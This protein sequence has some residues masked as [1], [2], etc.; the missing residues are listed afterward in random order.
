MPVSQRW[1]SL[2]IPNPASQDRLLGGGLDAAPPRDL[3]KGNRAYLV[4]EPIPKSRCRRT[5]ARRGIA[6]GVHATCLPDAHVP[7]PLVS[8]VSLAPQHAS[9]A[10]GRI[11]VEGP[12]ADAESA[13]SIAAR[14]CIRPRT[15]S[16]RMISTLHSS[17]RSLCILSRA[18]AGTASGGAVNRCVTRRASQLKVVPR[19][20]ADAPSRDWLQLWATAVKNSLRS[21]VLM[22]PGPPVLRDGTSPTL[23]YPFVNH[24]NY[25]H[26]VDR[27]EKWL[28][29]QARSPRTSRSCLTC[30]S[31]ARRHAVLEASAPD[32][33]IRARSRPSRTPVRS[34]LATRRHDPARDGFVRQGHLQTRRPAQL[35]R[36]CGRTG[37]ERSWHGR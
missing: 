7:E 9:H 18:R 37:C 33:R 31:L 10:G 28:G 35:D 26:K 14:A 36:D 22:W 19:A 32:G 11:L 24:Y 5:D 30:G 3:E 16:S 12:L 1:T 29:E 20:L 6:S 2:L 21:A 4:Y 13:A 27:V 25:H 34:A 23:W 17:T 15:A 8:P